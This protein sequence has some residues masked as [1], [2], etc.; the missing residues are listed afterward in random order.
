MRKSAI[1]EV[2]KPELATSETKDKEEKKKDEKKEINLR[3]S[4]TK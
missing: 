1:A 3:N 2:E 4:Y